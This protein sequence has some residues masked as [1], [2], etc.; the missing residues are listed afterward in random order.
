MKSKADGLS[1]ALDEQ[2]IH[3]KALLKSTERYAKYNTSLA[4][5]HAVQFWCRC[6]KADCDDDGICRAC[7]GRIL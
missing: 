4:R 7:K 1:I 2:D 3:T 5:R 6:E